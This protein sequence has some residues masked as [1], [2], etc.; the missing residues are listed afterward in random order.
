MY[1]LEG[2]KPTPAS[3]V[4]SDL[5]MTTTDPAAVLISTLAPSFNASFSKIGPRE[6]HHSRLLLVGV[7]PVALLLHDGQVHVLV[8]HDGEGD[9]FAG[10]RSWL[11]LLQQLFQNRF[12]RRESVLDRLRQRD[13]VSVHTYHVA[14]RFHAGHRRREND[15]RGFRGQRREVVQANDVDALQLAQDDCGSAENGSEPTIRMQSAAWL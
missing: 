9:A 10:P 11:H 13:D 3:P 15:V 8:R 2:M 7:A 6:P 5:A 1:R 4:A 14:T 12:L